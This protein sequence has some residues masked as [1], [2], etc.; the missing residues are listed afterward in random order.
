MNRIHKVLF[1]ILTLAI[2]IQAYFLNQQ[3]FKIKTLYKSVKEVSNQ[4]NPEVDLSDIESRIDD[5]ESETET[6]KRKINTTNTY[7]DTEYETR[8]LERR[9]DDLESRIRY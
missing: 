2:V 9:I 4:I 8:K 7:F 5:L 6:L 3:N 1:T